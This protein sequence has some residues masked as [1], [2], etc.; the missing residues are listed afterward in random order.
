[1]L[2]LCWWLAHLSLRCNAIRDELGEC[3]SLVHLDL[4]NNF[5]RKEG[6]G[7]LAD[8]LENAGALL[9]LIWLRTTSKMKKGRGGLRGCWGNAGRLLI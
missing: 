8:V 4:G 2:G 9:I 7:R 6:A 1:M 3:G 5:I